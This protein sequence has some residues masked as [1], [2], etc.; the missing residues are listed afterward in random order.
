[1][2]TISSYTE[3]SL[4]QTHFSHDAAAIL[5][6]RGL[7][8]VQGAHDLEALYRDHFPSVLQMALLRKTH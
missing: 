8:L 7:T 6:E 3:V 2:S 1:M 4:D 5:L